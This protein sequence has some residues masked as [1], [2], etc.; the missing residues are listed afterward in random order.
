MLKTLAFKY[1]RTR[2]LA[3]RGGV[4]FCDV[5]QWSLGWSTL[6]GNR[7]PG[8]EAMPLIVPHSFGP[9]SEQCK[10][11]LTELALSS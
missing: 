5:S 1:R 9:V 8:M 7:G 10:F 3:G 4:L 6:P 2:W 11:P